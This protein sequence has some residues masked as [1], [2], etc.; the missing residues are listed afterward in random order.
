MSTYRDIL[1]WGDGHH[2]RWF[3]ILRIILGVCLF[4]KGISFMSNTSLLRE[5]LAG[6]SLSNDSGWLPIL[7]TWMNLLGGFFLMVGLQTRLVAILELPILV[8]AILFISTQKSLFA[9]ESELGSAVVVLIL[10]L[11]FIV[12]GSGPASLDSYFQKNRDRQS[13]GTTLP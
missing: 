10:L 6:S 1:R 3:V 12:E 4:A 2:P 9:P 8:G 5:L 7:I 11:F 13:S